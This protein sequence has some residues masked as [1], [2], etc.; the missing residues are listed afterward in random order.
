MPGFEKFLTPWERR[1]DKVRSLLMFGQE[2]S[3]FRD[4]TFRYAKYLADLERLR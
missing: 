2:L 1:W 3:N 4:A